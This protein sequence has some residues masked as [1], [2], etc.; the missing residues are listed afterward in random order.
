MSK[1]SGILD[2]VGGVNSPHNTCMH[3]WDTLRNSSKHTERVISTQSSQEVASNRLRLNS[4]IESVR[5]LANQGCAFRGYNE[6]ANSSNGGNFNAVLQAF[7]RVNIEVHKVLHNAPG[8]AKYISPII[9][10]Q[11][12]NI[13]GNKV[14]TKIREEVGDAKFCILVGEVVD[15][16]NREQMAIILR[17]VGCDGFIRERFFKVISVADTCSQTLKNEIS[18][19]L[20]QYDLQVENMCGQG[21]DGASNMRGEFNGLQTLFREECPYAYYVH[22][23]AH[24]L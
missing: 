7:G 12:L 1:Q 6:S 15:V 17:F 24:R 18:K 19:V 3:K 13:L 14:R 22:C 23:F 16:C 5:L 11:I 10:R 4:T 2:H 8:N 21:Y 20:A 9:Q